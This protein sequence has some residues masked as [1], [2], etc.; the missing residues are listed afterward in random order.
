METEEMTAQAAEW[1]DQ[2]LAWITT[3]GVAFLINLVVALLIFTIGKWLAKK[4][5]GGIRQAMTARE[6]DPVLIGFVANLVYYIL[7]IA[8][9]IA[10]IQQIGIETT[11]FIAVLGAAGLAVGFALQGS[12]SNFASG[13][14]IILFRP[15]KLGDFIDAG[16]AAGI[17]ED[18]GILVCILRSPD[19]K[20][21]IVPNSAIMSGNITN[22]TGNDTRRVDMTFSCAYGD[23]IV[24]V[25][26][27][28]MDIVTAHPKTLDDPKPQ[29]EVLA[30]GASSIDFAVRPWSATSDYWDVFFDIHREV[31]LRFDQE[32]I[33]IPFPQQDVYMHQVS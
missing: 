15:F 23:D 27:V 18:I 14:L 17:V 1:M 2:L 28:L 25:R 22:F 8:V 13:V 5:T 19:N 30:H 4:I 21:I 10:A 31:K 9:V 33:S 32:G 12:L 26:D 16:G 7:F 24:K 11:S 29:I 6:V 3:S 20:K